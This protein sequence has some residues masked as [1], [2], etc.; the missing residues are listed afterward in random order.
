MFRESHLWLQ[1]L[2]VTVILGMS[3]SAEANLQWSKD[4]TIPQARS[5]HGVAEIDGGILVFG[6]WV[7][8]PQQVTTS[9]GIYHPGGGW[10]PTES[11]PDGRWSM[12]FTEHDGRAYSIAGYSPTTGYWGRTVQVWS[13]DPS[14]DTWPTAPSLGYTRDSAAAVSLGDYIYVIGGHH[15]DTG[16]GFSITNVERY[17]PSAGGSWQPVASLNHSREHLGAAV[18]DGKIYAIGGLAYDKYSHPHSWDGHLE[19]YDPGADE[20]TDGPTMLTPRST[21][22][23]AV[24]GDRIYTMGGYTDTTSVASDV[25]E[26]FDVSENEWFEDAAFPVP[27]SGARAVAVNDTIYVIGG[28]PSSDTQT[29]A[30]YKATVSHTERTLSPAASALLDYMRDIKGKGVI[31]GQF[32]DYGGNL[33][34]TRYEGGFPVY[35]DPLEPKAAIYGTDLQTFSNPSEIKLFA[36]RIENDGAIA[37]ISWHAFCEKDEN[38]DPIDKEFHDEVTND[39]PG[40]V[41]DVTSNRDPAPGSAAE[42]WM[43]ALVRAAGELQIFH[44]KGIVVLWRPLHEMN[45]NWFW[46]GKKNPDGFKEL[47]RHMFDYLTFTRGLTNLLWV[48]APNQQNV[49]SWMPLYG[50]ADVM[51]YYPEDYVDV[52]GLDVYLDSD[53]DSNFDETNYTLPGLSDLREEAERT[54]KPLGLSELGPWNHSDDVAGPEPDIDYT[55]NDAIEKIF[56]KNRDLAFFQAWN[57]HN[58]IVS[59]EEHEPFLG[60]SLIITLDEL[61]GLDWDGDGV[62]SGEEQGPSGSNP[63]YSGNDDPIPDRLQRNV[64]SFNTS[65]ERYVTLSSPEGTAL[66]D[67]AAIE[68]PAPDA[69]GAPGP[70]EAPYGFFRFTIGGVAVGGPTTAALR[71]PSRASSY[72]KYGPT[73]DN[74]AQ[75]WY[76][77]AFDEKTG[78]GARINGGVITLYL[79]DGLRGDHDLKANGKIVE[80]GGPVGDAEPQS[81]DELCVMSLGRIAYDPETGLIRIGATVKNTT[82]KTIGTPLWLVI[83]NVSDPTVALAEP[84]GMTADGMP[85]IDLSNLLTDSKLDPGEHLTAQIFFSNSRRRRFTFLASVRGVPLDVSPSMISVEVRLAPEVL[86]LKSKGVFTAFVELPANFSAGDIDI[87]TVTCHGAP[88]TDGRVTGQGVLAVKFDRQALEGVVPGDSIEFKVEGQLKYGTPFLGTDSIKV[89]SR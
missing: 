67:V 56:S 16:H 4:G 81:V 64:T 55:Y 24:V 72:H 44:D 45:G 22:A 40:F 75:H 23:I 25:V 18:V 60:H 26:Y 15:E 57:E 77:F 11:M 38:G 2:C 31:S 74:P 32:V 30:V 34:G 8:Q 76:E 1:L 82:S 88:A 10:T 84:S 28:A 71:L 43:A 13:Y 9:A 29:D 66:V 87:A 36:Q 20:W 42:K 73:P 46:W 51:E 48:Y 61:D 69:V 65:T 6:G 58:A 89:I 21:F 59:D 50:I 19:I 70:D 52:L 68:N 5:Q 63:G 80:P 79:V 54:G 78:T 49:P 27:V 14:T 33:S 35:I 83:T 39:F 17:N 12:A 85:Y 41:E 3:V 86:N 7:G 62:V 53:G 37:T 47:W